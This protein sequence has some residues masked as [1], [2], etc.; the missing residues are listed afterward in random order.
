MYEEGENVW[1]EI[2]WLPQ[3]IVVSAFYCCEK[4]FN[5]NNWTCYV[6][7]SRS[8]EM[9][10]SKG[11]SYFRVEWHRNW[12]SKDNVHVQN[13]YVSYI[14]WWPST[15]AGTSMQEIRLIGPV[16]YKWM[17]FL[18]CYIKEL[19]GHIKQLVHPEGSMA[20]G[21]VS[22]KAAFYCIELL[23]EIDPMAHWWRNCN[24]I[25]EMKD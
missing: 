2:T 24:S 1:L 16:H 22:A 5:K 18:E 19:K 3:H 14:F 11:N 10:L 15:L 7:I 17:Y 25:K 4:D 12:D 13:V 6:K 20:I 9:D 23:K 8:I 21:Y